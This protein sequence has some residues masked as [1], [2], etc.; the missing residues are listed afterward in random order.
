MVRQARINQ[1]SVT[2][3][4]CISKYIIYVFC[5]TSILKSSETIIFYERR[6]ATKSNSNKPSKRMLIWICKLS[7]ALYIDIKIWV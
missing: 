1:L 7:G 2:F 5:A 4:V 3:N 6:K